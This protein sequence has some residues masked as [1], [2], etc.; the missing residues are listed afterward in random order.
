MRWLFLH[1]NSLRSGAGCLS[2][3]HQRLHPPSGPQ[4]C[5]CPDGQHYGISHQLIG[6]S[7]CVASTEMSRDFSTKS[8]GEKGG[9]LVWVEQFLISSYRDKNLVCD[10]HLCN[11]CTTTTTHALSLADFWLDVSG[12][13]CDCV[14]VYIVT[15]GTQMDWLLP[16]GI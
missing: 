12:R 5:H 2:R 10:S 3:L 4:R 14:C 13:R 9:E 8:L 16:F 1:S 7:E 15:P 11:A 6:K